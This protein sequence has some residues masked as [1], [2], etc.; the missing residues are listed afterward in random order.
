MCLQ[1]FHIYDIRNHN[2][3][4]NIYLLLHFRNNKKEI[5]EPYLASQASCTIYFMQ[6]FY[7]ILIFDYKIKMLIKKKVRYIRLA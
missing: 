1:I 3:K 6:L 4:T 2:Y 5:E 7:V